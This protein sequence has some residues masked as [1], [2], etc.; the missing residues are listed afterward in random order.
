[1]TV[2]FILSHSVVVQTFSLKHDSFSI[3]DVSALIRL[4]ELLNPITSLQLNANLKTNYFNSNLLSRQPVVHLGPV[5]EMRLAHRSDLE[6]INVN[7]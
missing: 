6:T 2:N 7:Q 4:T 3:S 1:M 5:N